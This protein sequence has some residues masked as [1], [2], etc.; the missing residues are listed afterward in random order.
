MKELLRRTKVVIRPLPPSVTQSFLFSQVDDRFSDRYNWILMFCS[1]AA[2]NMEPVENLPSVEIQLERKEAELSGAPK[3]TPIVTPLMEFVRQKLALQCGTRA[4]LDQVASVALRRKSANGA[5]KSNFFVASKQENQSVTSIAKEVRENGT[6][7]GLNHLC[8][9][10]GNEKCEKRARNKDRPDRG[11]WAP[12]H[13][14]DVSQA[15]ERHLTASVIK[16]AQTSHNSI[17]GINASPA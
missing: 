15:S 11:V 7:E 17:E 9:G 4:S 6:G 14:S 1:L 2:E 13:G 3:E 12:S 16:S 8:R 5:K 10:S